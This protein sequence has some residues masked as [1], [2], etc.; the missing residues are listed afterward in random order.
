MPQYYTFNI[1][2]KKFKRRKNGTL[3]QGFPGVRKTDM[4]GRVY[5]V[6]LRNMECYCLRILLHK[7]KGPTSFDHLKTVVGIVCESFQK[8][9]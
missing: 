9:C 4:I 5:T 7:I 3:V 8:A 1:T 2:Q 6:H